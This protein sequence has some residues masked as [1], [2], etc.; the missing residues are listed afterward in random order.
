M[1]PHFRIIFVKIETSL[2]I[3]TP[4][5]DRI[6][7]AFANL[8]TAT[9]S[10][11]SRPE[12]FCKKVF[13]KFHT[14]TLFK[15]RLWHRCF[16]VNFVKFLRNRFLKNTS[17]GCFCIGNRN[18]WKVTQKLNIKKKAQLALWKGAANLFEYLGKKEIA[19]IS[20]PKYWKFSVDQN[21]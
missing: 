16:P 10:I 8:L 1:I 21:P 14:A 3:I 18:N 12:V 5:P 15:K 11:S 17:G 2:L 7:F 4:F 6:V 20:W 13:L 19:T 9:I